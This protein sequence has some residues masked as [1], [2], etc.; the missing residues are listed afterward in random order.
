L[1]ERQLS[2]L[3]NGYPIKR[4]RAAIVEFDRTSA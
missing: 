3:G 1:L 4:E 2:D